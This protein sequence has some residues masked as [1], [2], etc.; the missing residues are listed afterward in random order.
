MTTSVE[1]ALSGAR[2]GIQWI[3]LCSQDLSQGKTER[4][5]HEWEVL[6]LL[7]FLSC[8]WREKVACK[9]LS[10]CVIVPS[11][12]AASIST[13]VLKHSGWHG[14]AEHG[15]TKSKTG[16]LLPVT[17]VQRNR[18]HKAVCATSGYHSQVAGVIGKT[19]AARA[20][21]KDVVAEKGTDLSMRRW[22]QGR[23][24]PS[25]GLGG[26]RGGRAAIKEKSAETRY[27]SWNFDLNEVQEPSR[28]LSNMW[29]ACT[30]WCCH[31]SL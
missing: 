1:L 24:V 20:L 22:S 28:W 26:M 14:G 2:Q 29:L 7:G 15:N 18:W 16:F 19:P 5:I 8:K 6:P 31:S 9:D 25:Q 13:W 30:S 17:S 4:D 11:K 23:D 10:G 12:Q 21:H 27:L 3:L